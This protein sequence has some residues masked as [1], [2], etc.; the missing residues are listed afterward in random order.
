MLEAPCSRGFPEDGRGGFRT[1][2]LSRVKDED[3]QGGK[4][5]NPG[6]DKA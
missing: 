4:P 1:C 5:G 3:N 2:D 6:G